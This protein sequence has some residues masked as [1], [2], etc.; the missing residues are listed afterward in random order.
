MFARTKGAQFPLFGKL[1]CNNGDKTHPLY[2]YLM[3]TLP[4]ELFGGAL[5]W[6]FVKF[7]CNADGVPIKRYLPI[8]SPLSIEGDIKKLL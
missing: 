8:F 1:E 2:Q 5:K 6:N 3:E 7:L 4:E